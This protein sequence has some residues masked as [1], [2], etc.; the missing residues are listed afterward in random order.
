MLFMYKT[1]YVPHIVCLHMYIYIYDNHGM[2]HLLS[3]MH[4]KVLDVMLIHLML[5]ILGA[6]VGPFVDWC[7]RFP[8]GSWM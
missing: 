1:G 4:I 8:A 7:G 6:A 3:G 2:Y 5:R